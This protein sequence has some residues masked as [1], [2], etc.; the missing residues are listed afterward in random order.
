MVEF[1]YSPLKHQDGSWARTS[2]LFLLLQMNQSH[3]SL[4]G[5]GAPRLALL[6]QALVEDT[7]PVFR[8]FHF[9]PFID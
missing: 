2:R 4:V 8:C 6:E 9:L 3:V 7:L 1:Q 5:T